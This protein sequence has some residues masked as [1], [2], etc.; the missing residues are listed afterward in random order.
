MTYDEVITRLQA[1]ADPAAVAGMARF[2]ISTRATLGVSVPS[3]RKLARAAGKNQDLAQRLWDSGI[4]EARILAG[5]VA[6]PGKIT[7]ALVDKWVREFD[8]WDVC[9]QTCMNLF[10][11]L[12]FAYD[13]AKEWSSRQAE[14]EKRAGFALMA[15]L[16]WAD[17]NA[18]DAR[19]EEFFPFIVREAGDARKFVKKAVNWSLRQIGKRSLYLNKRALAV[20][21]EIGKID[22]KTARWVAVDAIRELT[23]P[24][25]VARIKR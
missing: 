12:P 17:K 10:D 13:K 24:A 8:S 16:A 11:R 9:D 15:C 22:S 4:H 14:F 18:A 1:L 23:N 3:I 2:G 5:M 7:E 25:S 19:F 21:G 20:A 6:E